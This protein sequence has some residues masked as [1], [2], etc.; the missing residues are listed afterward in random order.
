MS[1]VLS[2]GMLGIYAP[3]IPLDDFKKWYPNVPSLTTDLDRPELYKNRVT[4]GIETLKIALIRAHKSAK[5]HAY[6]NVEHFAQVFESVRIFIK[7]YEAVTGK[8]LDPEIVLAILFAAI[9][10]D[11]GHCGAT[12]RSKAREKEKLFLPEMGVDVSSEYVSMVAADKLAKELGFSVPARVFISFLI[13]ATTYGVDTDEGKRIKINHIEVT[14]LFGVAMRLCDVAPPASMTESARRDNDINISEIPSST[15][16][17]TLEEQL[18]NRIKFFGY[19]VSLMDLLDEIVIREMRESGQH[20]FNRK[21]TEATPWRNRVDTELKML[22]STDP[23]DGLLIHVLFGAFRE[24][25]E[26]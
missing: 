22:T 7:A 20:E 14:D 10:H 9:V 26:G 11:F 5:D 24:I 16:P 18:E 1:V 8:K 23:T 21:L 12:F 2:S 6:H 13:A 19:I 25:A 4:N 17:E 15:K 3:Y